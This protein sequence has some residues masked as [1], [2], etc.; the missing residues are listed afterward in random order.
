MFFNSPVDDRKVDHML[1]M[2]HNVE[3][4]KEKP[5]S[6][7]VVYFWQNP[8]DLQPVAAEVAQ[9]CGAVCH[10]IHANLCICM[11]TDLNSFGTE[12][13]SS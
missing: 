5:L 9:M 8:K 2:C 10:F 7:L 3:A 1:E 13:E 11:K 6:V 12:W 4:H